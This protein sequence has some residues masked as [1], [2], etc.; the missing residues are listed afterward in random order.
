MGAILPRPRC[1]QAFRAPERRKKRGLR[2]AAAH[3]ARPR[4]LSRPAKPPPH[5]P[6]PAAAGASPRPPLAPW[7]RPCPAPPH[8]VS[9]SSALPAQE[10]RL[11]APTPARRRA[12]RPHQP[13][14][15]SEGPRG[16]GRSIVAVGAGRALRSFR[17]PP[18]GRFATFGGKCPQGTRFPPVP[19]EC[20]RIARLSPVAQSSRRALAAPSARFA[21]HLRVALRFAQQPTGLTLPSGAGRAGS[22]RQ[23][24]KHS[25]RRFPPGSPPK[26]GEREAAQPRRKRSPTA[27]FFD[28]HITR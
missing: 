16:P 18:S 3:T 11:A 27:S 19:S 26:E 25:L 14:G 6:S 22:L 7:M 13:S 1:A 20:I 8:G 10:T 12:L 15:G 23:G 21:P 28:A 17:S 4:A 9:V 24:R 5:A 2:H